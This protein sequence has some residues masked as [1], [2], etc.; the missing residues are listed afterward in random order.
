MDQADGMSHRVQA[1]NEQEPVSLQTVA[2]ILCGFEAKFNQI[3]GRFSDF[4]ARFSSLNQDIGCDM[5][6]L[7]AEMWNGEQ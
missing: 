3:K 1:Q 4:N 7:K 6:S 2:G 5:R